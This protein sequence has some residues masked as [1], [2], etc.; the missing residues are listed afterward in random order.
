MMIDIIIPTILNNLR[1]CFWNKDCLRGQPILISLLKYRNILF[2]W[3]MTDPCI[4]QK[5]TRYC[6]YM[7][8]QSLHSQA[9][10]MLGNSKKHKHKLAKCE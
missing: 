2:T 9:H 6:T 8:V 5:N 4:Y 10:I 7:F 1:V 3:Y